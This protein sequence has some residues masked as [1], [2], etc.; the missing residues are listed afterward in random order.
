MGGQAAVDVLDAEQ[1]AYKQ[2]GST[3]GRYHLAFDRVTGATVSGQARTAVQDNTA[4]AYLGEI[5]PG[6]S[7]TSVQITN[8]LGLLQVSP[9]DTA[10]YLTQKVSAPSGASSALAHSPGHWYP[11]N[12]NF[13]RTFARVVPT[14]VQ[15]AAALVKQMQAQHVSTL[16]VADDGSDYGVTVTAGGQ[17][18]R[19]QGRDHG[20]V[21][22]DRGRRLLLRGLD[23]DRGRSGRRRQGARRRGRREPQGQAVRPLRA[24]RRR[25]RGQAG[26]RDPVGVDR[27]L[28]RVRRRAAQQPGHGLRRGLP[29]GLRVR[30]R[31]GGD[32]RL[33]GDAGRRRGAQA[34]GPE[35]RRPQPRWSRTSSRSSAA[36][37]RWAATRSLV[38]TRP[39][40][41]SSWRRSPVASWCPTRRGDPP[42]RPPRSG[43]RSLPGRADGDAHRL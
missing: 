5:V 10:A 6:S 30:A 43:R 17:G 34:G 37:R 32:L 33:R 13:H 25:L 36:S 11:A 18:R 41:R 40:H 31:A 19:D 15:E 21:Q 4:I 12:S 20:A 27:L 39:S 22:P 3:V 35:R 26:E 24:L 16:A 8:E 23:R 42:G 28:A 38:G 14:T 2:S 9:T 1:L 7:G 29:Q